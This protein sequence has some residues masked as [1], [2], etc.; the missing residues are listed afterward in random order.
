M[1]N[2]SILLFVILLLSSTGWYQAAN[3]PVTIVGA[4]KN[5]MRDRQ[6]QGMIQLDTLSPK[7]G[8]YGLGPLSFLTGELML[9]DGKSYKSQ[10]SSD[11]TMIVTRSFNAEAPFF[12]YTRAS[13]WTPLSLDQPISNITDLQRM[14]DKATTSTVEPFVFTLSGKIEYARVHIQNLSEDHEPPEDLH[15][16]Q[17]NFTLHNKQV[18]MV[19]FFS[20]NHQGIFTHH[21]SFLH[22]HLITADEKI[23]GHLDEVEF[24]PEQ[25]TLSVAMPGN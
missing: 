11:S 8:L 9:Y 12:V 1:R 25:M 17:M 7:K 18:K 4:L 24:K 19:G 22:I 21:D 6:L 5:V 20:R 23:M 16:R 10:S 2:T 14:I 13:Q 15:S 3:E